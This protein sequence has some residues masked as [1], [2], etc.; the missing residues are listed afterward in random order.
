MPLVYVKGLLPSGVTVLI[1]QCGTVPLD[2]DLDQVCEQYTNGSSAV[3]DVL[4]A[5]EDGTSLPSEFEPTSSHPPMTTFF[6]DHSIRPTAKAWEAMTDPSAKYA[7][8][9]GATFSILR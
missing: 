7:P 5:F 9:Q 4:A 6:L 3:A 2:A 8:I 1:N